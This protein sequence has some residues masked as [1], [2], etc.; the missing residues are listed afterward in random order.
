MTVVSHDIGQPLLGRRTSEV[1]TGTRHENISI[2]RGLQRGLQRSVGCTSQ[3]QPQPP[4]HGVV[5]GRS[6]TVWA[7]ADL[8]AAPRGAARGEMREAGR[9]SV[10][11]N[12]WLRS[13]WQVGWQTGARMAHGGMM[14]DGAAP[15]CACLNQQGP[16]A[17]SDVLCTH[18]ARLAP[19]LRLVPPTSA[20]L[21]NFQT[22]SEGLTRRLHAKPAI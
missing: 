13:R 10:I 9:N 7:A 8:L 4:E 19:A 15:A 2:I 17:R 18:H 14:A 16:Q 20:V 11:R 5:L 22:G 3:P 1:S 6:E 21:Q 12:R